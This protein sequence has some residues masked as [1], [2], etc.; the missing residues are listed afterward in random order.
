MYLLD[1][2]TLVFILRGNPAVAGNL[3][4]RDAQPKAFSVLSYGE[5]LYGA[6]KSARPLENAAKVRRL[7][8]VLPLVDVSPAVMETFA[9]LKNELERRGTKIGELDLIIASTAIHLSYTL[10]SNNLRHF[11]RVPGLRLET[12]A[13]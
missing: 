13:A 10:V 11:R 3:R 2:D 9:S 8:E 12:W 1:T 6:M 7:T 4:A 5:L